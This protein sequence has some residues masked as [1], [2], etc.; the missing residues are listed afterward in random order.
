MKPET[1]ESTSRKL[2][3]NTLRYQ[4]KP[5]VFL[6]CCQKAK[7]LTKIDSYINLITYT[8]ARET[9]NREAHRKFNNKEQSSWLKMGMYL[10]RFVKNKYDGL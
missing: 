9:L 8:A 1:N 6:I 3:E 10:N 4:Y 5:W 7:K 2:K